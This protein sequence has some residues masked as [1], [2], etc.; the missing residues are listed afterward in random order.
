M[1]AAVAQFPAPS[2]F[3]AG[4]SVVVGFPFEQV[5]ALHCVPAGHFAHCP[6]MHWAVVPQVEA[7][8]GAHIP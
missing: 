6:E 1:V 7:S 3:A 2:H 8:C 5:A 4:V